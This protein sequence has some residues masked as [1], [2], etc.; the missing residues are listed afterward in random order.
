MNIKDMYYSFMYYEVY[1]YLR[2]H[3]TNSVLRLKADV[4]GRSKS[5]EPS[6]FSCFLEWRTQLPR[7]DFPHSFIL[8]KSSSSFVV[9]QN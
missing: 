3:N 7:L 9:N 4:K 2:F 8:R 5:I 1:S 6:I